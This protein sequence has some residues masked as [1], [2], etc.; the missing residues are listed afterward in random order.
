MCICSSLSELVSACMPADGYAVIALCYGLSSL[1]QV[2]WQG[3]NVTLY[4]RISWLWMC[5]WSR[6]CQF[7]SLSMAFMPD[8]PSSGSALHRF[9]FVNVNSFVRRPQSWS[10]YQ[11]DSVKRIWYL[12]PMWSVKVQASLRIRAV[13]QNLRCSFIQAVNQEEPSD[14]KPDPWPLWIAGHAQL[15]FV[16]TECSKTQIRLTRP[17]C[18]HTM[19]LMQWILGPCYGPGRCFF[20]WSQVSGLLFL[21]CYLCVF[22]MRGLL[23]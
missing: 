5:R 22:S 21:N 11:L 9:K 8:D 10:I 13:S 14:R 3:Q 4:I 19:V 16:M 20:W 23:I 12:L 7:R 6:G 18:W 15:K 1:R 17:N 2:W